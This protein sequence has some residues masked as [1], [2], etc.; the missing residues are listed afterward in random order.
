MRQV[1]LNISACCKL[2][3]KIVSLVQSSFQIVLCLILSGV[4][5]CLLIVAFH[6]SAMAPLSSPSGYVQELER[7]ISNLYQIQGAEKLMDT[8]VFAPPHA[9][10]TGS[11]VPDFTAPNT[12]AVTTPPPEPIS[13]CQGS[14]INLRPWLSLLHLSRIT[15]PISSACTGKTWLPPQAP[16]FHLHLENRYN[17]LD[18]HDFLLLPV[19]TGSQP[20]SSWL[21]HEFRSP[22]SS[23][24]YPPAEPEHS[25]TESHR[26]SILSF[27]PA[28][29]LPMSLPSY[30]ILPRKFLSIVSSLSGHADSTSAFPSDNLNHRRLRCKNVLGFPR[31][32]PRVIVHVGTNDTS[33]RQTELTKIHFTQLLHFLKNCELSAFISGPFSTNGQLMVEQNLAESYHVYEI[34]KLYLSLRQKIP[35]DLE[36]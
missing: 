24:S 31:G 34:S 13:P 32:S 29:C 7:R 5:G 16:L 9:D 3:G 12:A 25:N 19:S 17:I 27:T 22:P 8:I 28:S 11:S 26:W 23:P 20:T 36:E 4:V 30:L 10:S 35:D 33:L 14:E 2:H 21:A 1:N 15:G 6:V 18:L